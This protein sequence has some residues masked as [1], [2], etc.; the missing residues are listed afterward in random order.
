MSF[1]R[2]SATELEAAMRHRDI[3]EEF[4]AAYEPPAGDPSGYL[5]KAWG[6]LNY[7]LEAART[8]VDLFFTAVPLP[9]GE[10]NGWT[11]EQVSHTAELLTNTPFATLA[12]HYDP[13]AMVAARVYPNMWGLPSNDG[14]GYLREYHRNLVAVFQHA[15]HHE[16]ALIQHF[17]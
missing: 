3:M 5:D 8:G 4:L 14:L 1:M 13:A 16:S 2:V 7:L 11:A 15:A 6:G 9:V 17:G 12:D 10:Y